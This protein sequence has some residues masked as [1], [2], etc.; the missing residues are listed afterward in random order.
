MSQRLSASEAASTHKRPRYASDPT[1]IRVYF[2]VPS[3]VSVTCGG[4]SDVPASRQPSTT[5]SKR[6][7]D[8]LAER[9]P[10]TQT[11]K[12]IL[13]DANAATLPPGLLADVARLPVIPVDL[14]S[15]NGV[16][17]IFTSASIDGM[18][19]GKESGVS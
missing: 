4:K 7:A 13:T 12:A 3:H 5:A 19:G 16:P 10:T 15:S 17:A 14:S 8:H 9:C 2:W 1:P 11:Q 6:N 18:L